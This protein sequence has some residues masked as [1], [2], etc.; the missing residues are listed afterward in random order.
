MS[1]TPSDKG[2]RKK[3]RERPPEKKVR[4]KV[5]MKCPRGRI[6]FLH[7]FAPEKLIEMN[8]YPQQQHT[9]HATIQPSTPCSKDKPPST[10]LHTQATSCLVYA[11]LFIDPF[12]GSLTTRIPSRPPADPIIT[13]RN[14]QAALFFLLNHRLQI[15]LKQKWRAVDAD[16]EDFGQGACLSNEIEK[17]SVRECKRKKVK[18]REGCGREDSGPKKLMH[19]SLLPSFSSSI[20]F[21]HRLWKAKKRRWLTWKW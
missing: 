7:E 14:L 19:V 1:P 3:N 4:E 17:W 11:A 8:E 10:L 21:V 13:N 9:A 6:F 12:F 16:N 5:E 15:A 2:N 20:P 18:E